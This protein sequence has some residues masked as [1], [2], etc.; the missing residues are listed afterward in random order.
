[1]NSTTA[2][3]KAT[4]DNAPKELDSVPYLK[5]NDGH[6]IPTMGYGV[7]TARYK[8]DPT[9]PLDKDLIKTMVMAIKAGYYHL[10]AA[11]SYGNEAELGTA[12]KEAGIPREKLFIT[13]KVTAH[14][15][16]SALLAFEASLKKL[17]VDYVD[18][19]LIHSPFFANGSEVILQTKWA[20]LEAI[21]ASG[22]ARSIGVSNYLQKDLEATLKTAKVVP[23]VNQI[24]YHP[25]LQHGAL[26]DYHREKG[27]A[28]E[29]YG[30]LTAILKGAPG[31]LDSTYDELAKKYGVSPGEIALR[32]VVDQGLVVLTTSAKEE[33]LRGYQKVWKFKLTPKE[34][35]TVAE[36]GKK[37]HFRGF[38]KD[39][40]SDDDRS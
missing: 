30:P 2:N 11:E 37:K 23:A 29:A 3:F 31:P 18:L 20:E 8:A 21:Q 13:T 5:L 28:T 16:T 27:I 26:L 15:E 14:T 7:G 24:E 39:K 36:I 25:Y 40:F 10:D 9:A 34:V 1:M 32:W 33:R 6:E 22:R 12:I 35:E 4:P 17:Q 19:Y 38:W